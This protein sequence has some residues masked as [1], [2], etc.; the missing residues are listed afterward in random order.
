MEKFNLGKEQNF[1][2]FEEQFNQK[3]KIESLGG[4]I[5]V[6]DIKPE[7]PKTEVPVLFAPGWGETHKTFKDSL[8]E[9]SELG[10]RVLSLS[11]AR[12]GGDKEEVQDNILNI[13]E[14]FADYP[15]D[16]LR[17]ALTLFSCF[18]RKKY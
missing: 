11:H 14:R 3:E 16:E 5:E 8:E 13:T 15:A 7:Q 9:M 12:D 6:V 17:K 4:V 2:S 10:R 18:R 1:V